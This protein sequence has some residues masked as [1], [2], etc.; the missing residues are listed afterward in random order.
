MEYPIKSVL[1]LLNEDDKK[2]FKPDGYNSTKFVERD[3]VTSNFHEAYPIQSQADRITG[4]QLN[5]NATNQALPDKF[6]SNTDGTTDLIQVHGNKTDLPKP[7]ATINYPILD[8]KNINIPRLPS[9]NNADESKENTKYQ[10]YIDN[11]TSEE[12]TKIDNS[13]SS[14]DRNII[15]Y[16]IAT[17]SANSSNTVLSSNI[18]TLSLSG[19]TYESTTDATEDDSNTEKTT[20][21]S[22]SF[23]ISPEDTNM[24][25]VSSEVTTSNI[26]IS[27]NTPIDIRL[28]DD[29]TSN[30]TI[31]DYTPIN[32]TLTEDESSDITISDYTTMDIRLSEDT[33][34]YDP[35]LDYGTKLSNDTTPIDIRLSEDTT[36]HITIP[37]S[38]SIAIRLSEETT[39]NYLISD[40]MKIDTRFS[41]DTAS[42]NPTSDYAPIDIRLSEDTTRDVTLSDSTPIGIRLSEETTS[43]IT[44]PNSTPIGIRLSED[45]TDNYPITNYTTIGIRLSEDTS[46]DDLTSD[47]VPIGIRLSEETTSDITISDSS[48]IGIRLSE[49][50]T[51]NYLISDYTTIDTR[52]SEGTI[53]DIRVP[54]YTINKMLLSASNNVISE[55]ANSDI[56][57]SAT[58]DIKLNTVNANDTK[59]SPCVTSCK[60]VFV[61]SEV[62]LQNITGDAQTDLMLT[63]VSVNNI[64]GSSEAS[65]GTILNNTMSDESNMVKNEV[66]TQQTPSIIQTI[67][68]LWK[69]LFSVQSNKTAR[70]DLDLILDIEHEE[71]LENNLLV[72]ISTS[73][74]VAQVEEG[75]DTITEK[76]TNEMVHDEIEDHEEADLPTLKKDIGDTLILRE[77]ISLDA[78]ISQSPSTFAEE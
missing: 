46:S 48:P 63:G 67:S 49:D 52:L 65:D 21:E 7:G 2:H 62:N 56:S 68:D 12:N 70:S 1:G 60:K 53:S 58:I 44:I 10:T 36:S 26:P 14:L 55:H 41:E 27:D 74:I 34:S 15:S 28:A 30:I 24:H 11:H 66:K 29:I 47:Y 17:E 6:A 78:N 31:S 4:I 13:I 5:I 25:T 72:D 42:D 64:D 57:T 33:A 69:E 19:S 40:Y 59:V 8:N 77:A 45:T 73:T 37:N 54:N 50:T 22:T 16:N 43:E 71:G 9:E 20:L 76:N 51:S 39:S 61:N 23:E 38:T 35:I 75:T 32:I 18:S 3:N